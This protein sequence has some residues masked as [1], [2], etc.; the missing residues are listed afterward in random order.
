M[1]TKIVILLSIVLC[2]VSCI[3][4]FYEDNSPYYAKFFI[5]NST[6]DKLDI[7][8][9]DNIEFMSVAPKD[10]VSVGL[11]ETK[12]QK[13]YPSFNVTLR[14]TDVR[15]VTV[16]KDGAIVKVWTED[17]GEDPSRQLFNESFWRYYIR[18]YNDEP[19]YFV[20]V[21]DILPEDIGPAD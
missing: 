7:Q 16:T 5:K 9:N 6:E 8:C 19:D 21:F 4:L 15:S 11:V 1:G 13:G 2:S 20:W 3:H 17:G 14:E 10:S 12:R 18:E